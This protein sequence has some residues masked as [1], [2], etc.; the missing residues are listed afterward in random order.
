[1]ND[2]SP[3]SPFPPQFASINFTTSQSGESYLTLI[4]WIGVIGD[5]VS[6]AKYSIQRWMYTEGK[7]V[8]FGEA[9]VTF[10]GD[11]KNNKALNKFQ[12]HLKYAIGYYRV[13]F[14]SNPS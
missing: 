11:I 2:V 8:D 4:K 5:C 1:M 9:L 10:N 13:Y 12:L 3:L 14:W 6:V 7:S